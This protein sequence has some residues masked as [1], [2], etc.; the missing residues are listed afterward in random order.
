MGFDDALWPK[1]YSMRIA[2]LLSLS[3]LAFPACSKKKDDAA[4]GAKTADKAAAGDDKGAAPAGGP[5]KTDPKALWADF[6]APNTDAMKLLDKYHDGASFSGK[7][8]VKGAEESGK[9]IIW[10]DI[11]GTNHMS[12]DYTDVAKAKAV[13]DGDTVNVTC[14]VGGADPTM[15]LMMMTD[16]S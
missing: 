4:G 12:L 10:V 2:L 5:V 7:A 14:K 15:K 16:C 8:S 3:L 11:D 9:P 13:K 6:T 1:G